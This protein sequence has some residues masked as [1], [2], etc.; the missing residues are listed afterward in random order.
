MTRQA[1]R[2]K[3]E[4][5]LPALIDRF[6]DSVSELKH[7]WQGDA[8]RFSFQARGFNVKGTLLVT[9][10][11]VAIDVKLPFAPRLFEGTIRS[12]AEQGLDRILNSETN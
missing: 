1:A 6:G 4:G 9:D 10:T 7:T 11:E 3:L 8:A 5:A 12:S 2:D